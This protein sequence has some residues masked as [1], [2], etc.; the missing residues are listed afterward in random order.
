M[1]TLRCGGIFYAHASVTTLKL[2]TTVPFAFMKAI[3]GTIVRHMKRLD[4]CH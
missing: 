1:S 4:G 2:F 3:K